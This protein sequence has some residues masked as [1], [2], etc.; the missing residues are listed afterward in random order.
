MAQIVLTIPDDSVV[1]FRNAFCQATGYQAQVPNVAFDPNNPPGP[2]NLEFIPNPVSKMAWVRQRLME[3]ALS[4]AEEAELAEF[5][6][7]KS[8]DRLTQRNQIRTE[9]DMS[10]G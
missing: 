8:I 7:Q 9:I 10:V 3:Y 2:G 6:R 1:R 5:D 4:T